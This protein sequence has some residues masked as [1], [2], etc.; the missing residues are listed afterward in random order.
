M[1]VEFD[2]FQLDNRRV[3]NLKGQAI[4]LAAGETFSGAGRDGNAERQPTGDKS[5]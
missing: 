4:L 2:K 5:F 3:I 1:Q